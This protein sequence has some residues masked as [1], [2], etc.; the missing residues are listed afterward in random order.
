MREIRCEFLT[1]LI[2]VAVQASLHAQSP[3]TIPVSAPPSSSTPATH[4]VELERKLEAISSALAA[5]HQQLDQS[6]QEMEQLREELAQIKKQLAASQPGSIES[7]ASG[8]ADTARAT[9]AAIEDLQER[10]ETTE[11]QVK[12]HDQ[13]KVETSSKYPLHV[14]GLVLFNTFINRGSVDN[15]DLPAVAL[16]NQNNTTGNGSSGGSFRQ[17]ILGLQGYGPTIAGARTSADVNL[18]FFGGLAYSSYA[19]SAGTVRMRTASISLDWTHDSLQ[20]GLMGPLIS[21]LSPTSYAM[22]AEPALAGAGNLWT[23]APQL[24]YAHRIPVRSGREVQVEFGLWDPPTA[25]YSTN[26]LFRVPSP[27]EASKQ[28][29]YESRVAYGTFAGDHPF[30]VGLSGYYSRQS[31][32]GNQSVDSWAVATDWR[33]PLG[34]RFE[35]SGEGYRGR[36][37]GGLGGGVYKDVLFGVYEATGLNI[38]RGLNAIGGWT[39][40]KA[41]IARSLEANASIGLDDGYAEDFHEFVF[42]PTVSSTQLRARNKMVFGNLIFR[43]KTY[44]IVSPEYRRI[45]TWPIYGSGNTADIFTLSAG[46]Q[47]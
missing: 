14:T 42:P 21:P 39:Q 2:L 36:A 22:V 17:T 16:N 44:L 47:F 46:Y 40:L 8:S 28:P 3:A 32:P 23:W 38:Y 9:A 6:R 1:C 26:Q 30:Q 19:T 31:Y 11:S 35:I 29:G 10:Q 13:T 7:S 25:G 12:I 20:A 24:R 43:P 4:S 18:D 37:L 33:V 41:H 34:S 5:T 27:G 15:I 45:W